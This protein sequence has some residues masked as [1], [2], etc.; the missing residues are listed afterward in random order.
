MK[1]Y[2]QVIS[3]LTFLH[4]LLGSLCVKGAHKSFALIVDEID[5]L[6]FNSPTYL[7]K[8]FVRADPQ[9]SKRQS[10]YQCLFAFLGSKQVK[11]THKM[12]LMKLTPVIQFAKILQAAFSPI[13]FQ[14][15][16]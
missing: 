4:V 13:S 2:G 6:S 12:L 9:S 5:P 7:C 15:K 10:S 14:Q 11:A 8:A 16:L 3:L 1:K